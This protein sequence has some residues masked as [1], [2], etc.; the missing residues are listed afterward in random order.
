MGDEAPPEGYVQLLA[1]QCA[2]EELPQ[3]HYSPWQCSVAGDFSINCRLNFGLGWLQGHGVGR[4]KRQA[5]QAAAQAV[6]GQLTKR[7]ALC[8]YAPESAKDRFSEVL[9]ATGITYS[10]VEDEA[11]P[12]VN[13]YVW[14]PEHQLWIR[15]NLTVCES[16]EG[17]ERR[18]EKCAQVHSVLLRLT[19]KRLT[20]AMWAG[21]YDPKGRQMRIVQKLWDAVHDAWETDQ[22]IGICQLP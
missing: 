8:N 22:A 12:A 11:T 2:L 21:A 6:S 13:F 16:K 1:H 7:L 18:Q 9:E 10:R 3:P 20:L 17:R 15:V 14:S 5:K 19:R 4:S